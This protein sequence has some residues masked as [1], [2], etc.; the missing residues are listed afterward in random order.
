MN[1][2]C[3]TVPKTIKTASYTCLQEQFQKP[4]L[5]LFHNNLDQQLCVYTHKLQ[6]D[7]I[8]NFSK[9]NIFSKYFNHKN[10]SVSS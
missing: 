9:T 4:N 10:Y 7:A 5:Y 2:R 1:F 3:Q 8:Y 6:L